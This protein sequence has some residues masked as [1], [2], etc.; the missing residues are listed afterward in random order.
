MHAHTHSYMHTATLRGNFTKC[1]ERTINLP[2]ESL[3]PDPLVCIVPDALESLGS[4]VLCA[5]ASNKEDGGEGVWRLN[6]QTLKAFCIIYSVC[7]YVQKTMTAAEITTL[8]HLTRP[9]LTYCVLSRLSLSLSNMLR[10]THT[11]TH[12]YTQKREREH[13]EK[14][15]SS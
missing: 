13:T 5:G 6:L 8:A 10:L 9:N 14:H 3:T 11:R 2:V 7:T 1:T 12:M 4:G 15:T